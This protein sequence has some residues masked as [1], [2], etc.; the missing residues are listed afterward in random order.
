MIF[1]TQLLHMLKKREIKL[2]IQLFDDMSFE[3][4]EMGYDGMES[5]L[6]KDMLMNHLGIEFTDEWQLEQVTEYL[7]KNQGQLENKVKGMCL[8]IGK[9]VA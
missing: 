5:E 8:M 3:I 1:I 2:F 4:E 7:L 6:V 9:N